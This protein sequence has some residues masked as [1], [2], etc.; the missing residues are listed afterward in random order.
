M[1]FPKKKSRKPQAT[2]WYQEI[3]QRV[4]LGTSEEARRR[5]R[6]VIL[7]MAV[8][9][10]GTLAVFVAA[11]WL[12]FE[13]LHDDDV[14]AFSVVRLEYRTDGALEEDWVREFTGLTLDSGGQSP[15]ELRRK[16][17]SYPQIL[18]AQVSRDEKNLLKISLKE[19]SGI[20]R[21]F[22]G[23]EEKILAS[24]GV[25][26]PKETSF[27]M[28]QD[29]LPLVLDAKFFDDASGLRKIA[30]GDVLLRFLETVR[31]D[32]ITLLAEWES[33]SVHDLPDE[34]FSDELSQPWAVL[35]VREHDNLR[36]A[37]FPKIS[38]IVFSAQNFEKELEL[39]DSTD[40][41]MKLEKHFANTNS[42]PASMRVV[43]ISNA[44]NIHHPIPE[45]RIIP[46]TPVT[47][48]SVGNSHGNVVHAARR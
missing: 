6:R 46:D 20:A 1:P 44:K 19:R 22:D 42:K 45:I 35:H 15:I 23:A 39:W 38:E 3:P 9:L 25:L 2:W 36:S 47:T 32:H 27:S 24:D 8:S 31:R 13:M 37:A 29:R 41:Q 34:L 43:F 7:Q 21:V 26:F 30:N 28:T 11:V 16:L 14:S 10:F 48:T 17:E 40:T 12:V 5:K 33:I 4:R 18:E